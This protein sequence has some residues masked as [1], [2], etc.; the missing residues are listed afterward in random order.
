VQGLCVGPDVTHAVDLSPR[1]EG[2]GVGENKVPPVNSKQLKDFSLDSVHISLNDSSSINAIGDRSNIG[3]TFSASQAEGGGTTGS[4]PL[5]KGDGSVPRRLTF[6]CCLADGVF[7]YWQ[8]LLIDQDRLFLQIPDKF[9]PN[10]SRDSLVC[11]LDYAERELKCSHVIISLRK[12][13][14][15]LSSL[16]RLFMYIGFTLLQPRHPII[17]AWS[18]DYVYMAYLID[19]DDNDN[20]DDDDDDDDDD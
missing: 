15:D 8:T 4:L 11:L 12:E 6:K 7:A 5:Q 17:P 10:G 16:M 20:V 3:G 18:E 13:R 2:N 19:C 1:T 9:Q 14:K